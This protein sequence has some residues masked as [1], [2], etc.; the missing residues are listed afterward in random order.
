MSTRLES[1]DLAKEMAGVYHIFI[2]IDTNPGEDMKVEERLLKI[3]EI[4]EVHYVS[5]QYDILAV[6]DINLRGKAIFSTVQ[7]L[8]QDLIQKIRMIPG[9]RD[10][11]SMVPF[12]S[13]VKKHEG[14]E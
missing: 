9:V 5:G 11:N 14:R 12:R 8:S 6:A 1:L 4:V 13:L 3:D 7:E 10:T 2:L